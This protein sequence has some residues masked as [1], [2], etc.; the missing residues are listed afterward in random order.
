MHRIVIAATALLLTVSCDS[1]ESTKGERAASA[2][3]T[4][5]A[6]TT[7][8]AAAQGGPGAAASGSFA[9][10][11]ECLSSCDR[12]DVI[13]TNQATCRLNCD[14]AYGASATDS[15]AGPADPV[16][17]A[18][19]CLGTCYA[20]SSSPEACAGGCKTTAAAA[21]SPPAAGVLDD[22]DTCIRT[23]HADKTVIP[24]NRRTCEL[25]CTQRARVAATPPPGAAAA[26]AP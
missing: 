13:P 18:G 3:A 25:N 19:E 9:S 22:L 20:G 1:A 26:T 11:S 24:T 17:R 21:A 2:P 7:P 23:C 14:A 6:P 4:N 16:T 8:A 5:Q 15:K 10:L 12:A